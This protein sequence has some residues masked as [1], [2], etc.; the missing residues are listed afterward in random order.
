MLALVVDP[1]LPGASFYHSRMVAIVHL[2]TVPWLTGSILGAFY[3]VAPLILR[4]SMAAG[5]GRLARLRRVAATFAHLHIAA[6]GWAT[7]MVVG[8][9]W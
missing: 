6:V 9:S 1:T 4:I 5:R 8:L 3:I 2:L 7:M